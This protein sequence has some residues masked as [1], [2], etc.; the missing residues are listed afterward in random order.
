MVVGYNS[1]GISNKFLRYVYSS[2]RVPS[3]MNEIRSKKAMD[4]AKM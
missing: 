2:N 1:V 4:D 3:G